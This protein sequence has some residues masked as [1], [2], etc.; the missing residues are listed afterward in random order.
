MDAT[1]FLRGLAWN[2]V[3]GILAL[4]VLRATLVPGMPLLWWPLLLAA[5]FGFPGTI[6]AVLIFV[7]L[8]G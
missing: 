5:V 4:L 7:Y 2:A 3:F 8:Q 6:A 1:R